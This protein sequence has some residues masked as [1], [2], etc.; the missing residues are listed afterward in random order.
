MKM[1]NPISIYETQFLK[2]LP[3]GH[4]FLQLIAADTELAS[5][6]SQSVKRFADILVLHLDLKPLPEETP[7]KRHHILLSPQAVEFLIDSLRQRMDEFLQAS[8][9]TAE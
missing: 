2:Q 9:E 8:P 1:V 7:T 3:E 6:Q 5:Y 4:E